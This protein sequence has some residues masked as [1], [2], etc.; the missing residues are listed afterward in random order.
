MSRVLLERMFGEL[1]F[2]AG[3]V[4]PGRSDV[5]ATSAVAHQ[6]ASRT[7]TYPLRRWRWL[8]VVGIGVLHVFVA[9][10]PV[11]PATEQDL[12]KH[13]NTSW[14]DGV[15]AYQQGRY[16][17]GEQ[18]Y[19]AALKDAEQLEPRDWRLAV[20]LND[21]GTLYLDWEKYDK[22]EQ[23]LEQARKVWEAFA[24]PVYAGTATTLNNLGEVYRRQKR[25][26][27]A[28]PLLSQALVIRVKVL[29]PNHFE[30]GA[31]C[32]NLGQLYDN[33][34]QYFLAEALY[35]RA[36][37]IFEKAQGP[38][39]RWVALALNNLG[40]LYVKQHQYAK[41]E[42]LLRKALAI[43]E[44]VLPPDHPDIEASR[45]NLWVLQEKRRIFE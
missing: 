7:G 24:G 4:S 17:E 20:T 15:A 30:V 23:R 29:G 34:S 41:A 45:H 32:N 28:E 39:N 36:L 38:A 21:L 18:L 43:R 22:A 12:S 26:S 2:E 16:R 10:A 6:R 37:A 19:L 11:G 40:A 44:Q 5:G 27:E 42:P 33:Q 35:E 1:K 9:C 13:W 25:Y 3:G 8:P 31:T 14:R